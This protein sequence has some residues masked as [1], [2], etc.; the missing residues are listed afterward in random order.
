MLEI[1]MK[2]LFR[3]LF[4]LVAFVPFHVA[5]AREG[6]PYGP[7]RQ[8]IEE[9]IRSNTVQSISV[10]VFRNGRVD[11]E[12]S[13]GWADR[14]NNIRATPHTIYSI[15]S[16]SKPFTT[17]ALMTLV[18]RGEIALDLPANDYLGDA[19]LIARIGDV[20]GATVMR[21]A[22]HTSGLPF[23]AQ[24]FYSDEVARRPDA[25][26]TIR[27]YGQL[28]SRPGERYFYSNLGYGI[29]DN[30]IARQTDKTYAAAMKDL[31]FRPLRL[32]DTSVGPPTSRSKSVAARYSPA[33]VKLPSYVTDHA[34]ASEVYSSAHDMIRFAAFHLKAHLRGQRAILSD[35]LIDQMHLNS[36]SPGAASGYGIGFETATRTNYNVV[37][38]GGFMPGVTTQMIMVPSHKTAIVVL[39]NT[40]SR[41]I[42]DQ[43]ADQI[44]SAVL[45][46]WLA[47]P[48]AM[49][50]EQEGAFRPSANLVGTWTGK[51]SRREG[52]V[53]ATLTIGVDGEISAVIGSRAAVSV[54]G[55]SFDGQ[56]LTGA[57]A[58]PLEAKETERF[59][60][61]IR[62]DIKLEGQRLYGVAAA[63]DDLQ[64]PTFKAGLS[65]W[66]DLQ[67]T[68]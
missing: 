5:E 37:S 21:V 17:T 60:N 30:I 11:W 58:V 3:L 63:L 54:L 26:E 40:A 45:P 19:K 51:I 38:H 16:I 66:F 59:Q 48:D 10:A 57:I 39:S 34:G 56:R 62:F 49:A 61:N 2:A 36:A 43:I 1:V 50:P 12:Q 41:E 4:L 9:S 20:K 46:N 22:N 65:Y 14:E 15:A 27:T 8:T 53:P 18:S 7:A 55:A 47:V 35:A 25:D 44:A 32:N 6:D 52:D 64:S 67:K 29:L 68:P 13:Y 28:M 23:H 31:V 24:F 42:V 33:G